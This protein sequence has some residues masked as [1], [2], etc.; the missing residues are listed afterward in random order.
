MSFCPDR[1][2]IPRSTQRRGYVAEWNARIDAPG[3]PHPQ[4]KRLL[5]V[6]KSSLQ[7]PIGPDRTGP[8]RRR[9]TQLNVP[10][11]GFGRLTPNFGELGEY[12][13]LELRDEHRIRP[14]E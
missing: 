13:A 14:V 12:L 10:L 7:K 1:P 4:T 6:I 9:G 2:C 5:I 3:R 11:T 8:A